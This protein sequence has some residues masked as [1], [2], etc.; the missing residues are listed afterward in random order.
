MQAGPEGC[1][2]S[3]LLDY[4]FSRLPGRVTV[5]NVYCSVQT[6]ADQVMQKLIQVWPLGCVVLAHHVQCIHGYP[7]V[8]AIRSV[9]TCA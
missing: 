7:W 1:G 4:C 5:A 2:K 8:M 6:T 9:Y 3:T